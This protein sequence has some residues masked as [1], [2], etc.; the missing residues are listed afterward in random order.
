M[1]LGVP[2]SCSYCRLKSSTFPVL[3]FLYGPQPCGSP[4]PS[5]AVK[6]L[7]GPLIRN[8][9]CSLSRDG[10]KNQPLHPSVNHQFKI[11]SM[12]STMQYLPLTR[13]EQRL[14]TY[15]PAQLPYVCLPLKCSKSLQAHVSCSRLQVEYPAH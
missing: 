8:L 2:R 15:R 3:N 1:M 13:M 5:S 4:A 6:T 11:N 7:T 12:D 10:R 9:Y 14:D